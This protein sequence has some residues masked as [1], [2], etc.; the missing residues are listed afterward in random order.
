MGCYLIVSDGR[1][2]DPDMRYN[3]CAKVEKNG[4]F[5]CEMSPLKVPLRHMYKHPLMCVTGS[6]LEPKHWWN[7]WGEQTANMREVKEIVEP[8]KAP[9]ANDVTGLTEEDKEVSEILYKAITTWSAYKNGLKKFQSEFPTGVTLEEEVNQMFSKEVI[10]R[11]K[12]S[13]NAIIIVSANAFEGANTYTIELDDAGLQSDKLKKLTCLVVKTLYEREVDWETLS[14]EG[15]EAEEIYG[16]GSGK[17]IKTMYN[18]D[19]ALKV[20]WIDYY[21]LRIR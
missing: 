4:E 13:N 5:I 11:D 12:E 10:L 20:W 15:Y 6:I 19:S 14:E 21:Q 8:T 17:M 3:I 16:D 7:I 2:Y 18:F 1:N 9:E